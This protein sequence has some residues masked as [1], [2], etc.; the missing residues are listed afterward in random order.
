MEG[1]EAGVRM[2]RSVGARE[3]PRGGERGGDGEEEFEVLALSPEKA[4]KILRL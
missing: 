1:E 4:R 2:L 3:R